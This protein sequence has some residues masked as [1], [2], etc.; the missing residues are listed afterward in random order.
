[1]KKIFLFFAL[2][3][4]FVCSAGTLSACSERTQNEKFSV[5]CTIF[6][7]YDWVRNLTEGNEN[8]ELTI[9]QASGQ[10][11]HNFQ[12]S[13]ADLVKI[14]RCDVFIYVGGESDAWVESILSDSSV[15]PDMKCIDLLA[16]LGDAALTEEE[17]P[18]AAHDHEEDHDHA[19]ALDEHVWLSLSNANVL[20]KVICNAICEADPAEAELYRSNLERYSAEVSALEGE[21]SQMVADAERTVI[22]FGDRFPFRYLAEDYG[23]TYY[24][25]FSGCSAETEASFSVITN[26]ARA[27]DENNLPYILVLENSD[28]GIAEQIRNNTSS[29]DQGILVMNSIQ[30]VTAAQIADGTTYLALMR[31]NF[32]TLRT[33]L[34]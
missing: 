29:K 23:L 12:P 8:V 6:P 7:Q 26:L 14:Y 20:L 4:A 11:L 15:N 31:G 33:A 19:E 28:R 34:N 1:M 17:V 9:L 2:C 27:V 5:V 16:A 24:A 25:A 10:D 22:L 18:G 32:E 30:S 3:A 13:A 21:Y